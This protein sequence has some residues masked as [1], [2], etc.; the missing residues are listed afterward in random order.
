[1]TSDAHCGG[2][3]SEQHSRRGAARVLS[4]SRAAT[5]GAKPLI[6]AVAFGATA[7]WPKKPAVGMK[8]SAVATATA[9][10]ASTRRNMVERDA[11]P[12]LSSSSVCTDREG[13][14]LS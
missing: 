9:A 1:M 14:Q 3:L 12:G 2:S 5:R 7:G 4:D 6:D 11:V 13:E 10:P 8:A